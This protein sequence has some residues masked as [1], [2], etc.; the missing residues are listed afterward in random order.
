L[1]TTRTLHCDNNKHS[2]TIV[3]KTRNGTEHERKS[4]SFASPHPLQSRLL[5]TSPARLADKE[6][7]GSTEGSNPRDE[8]VG[9]EQKLEKPSV[10]KNEHDYKAGESEKV[11]CI[12]IIYKFIN[13]NIFSKPYLM[14]Y[15]LQFY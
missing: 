1:L 7:G 11:I 9:Q 14:C 4:S 6:S 8:S 3:E 12:G 2:P 15:T 10:G 13:K 5:A